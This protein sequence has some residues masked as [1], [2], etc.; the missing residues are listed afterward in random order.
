MSNEK[1]N[2]SARFFIRIGVTLLVIAAV[3][4][5]LLAAINSLTKDKIA[6][7]EKQAVAQYIEQIFADQFGS[8]E[9]TELTE[10][11]EMIDAVY[12]VTL[13]DGGEAWCFRVGG[14]GFGG[15][16]SFII[17]TDKEGNIKGIK[18]LS[19]SETPGVGT[20]AVDNGAGYLDN[21]KNVNA[22]DGESV[23]AKSGATYSS[24]AVKSAV[25]TVAE[26]LSKE[27]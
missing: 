26:Y 9:E 17:G 5:A 6:E 25:K 12:K 7:N 2:M 15:K 14:N 18:T 1:K 16:V 22:A 13:T 20:K 4:A 3:V 19:H 24:K 8:Y 11:N 21:Y 27:G 23:A 10:K